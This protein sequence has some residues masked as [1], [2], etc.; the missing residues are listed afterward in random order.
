M[1]QG[2]NPLLLLL[3][4]FLPPRK[5][6]FI[7]LTV[8]AGESDHHI[9]SELRHNFKKTTFVHNSSNH[10]LH[11]VGFGG[12]CRYNCVQNWVLS[13]TVKEEQSD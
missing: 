7:I 2:G 11:V 9:H 3:P 5:N 4:P 13:K 10:F 6:S 12:V 1:N 8:H